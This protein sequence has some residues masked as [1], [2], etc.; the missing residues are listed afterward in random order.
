VRRAPLA[1]GLAAL[2]LTASPAAAVG[3]VTIGQLAPGTIVSCSKNF[4][5]LQDSSPDNAYVMPAAGVIT[6]WAHRSQAGA[7]QKVSLKIFR[8]IGDP[9]RYQL[10][11]HDG[12]HPVVAGT[13][14]TFPASIA[15]NAGDVLGLT[16]ESGSA[17]IG[18][19]FN[20]PGET[21]SHTPSLADGGFADFNISTTHRLNLTAVLN[22][23]N[24][25]TLGSIT[26]HK[27]KGTASLAVNLPNPGELTAS[28]AGAS[29]SGAAVISKVV[30]A[31]ATSLLIKAKGKKR[32][33]LNA[34]GKVKLNLTITYSPTGGDPSSQSVKVKLKKK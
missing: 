20:G 21:A 23:A 16:G 17:S 6:S 29:A 27:K 4:D 11:G 8:K 26:R 10:V 30:S 14:T 9:T 15:V 1:I 25:F 13:D 24:T 3:S 5:F 32:K 33:T 34:T 2:A 28:G 19:E 7:G 22:P 18:C 31:G 12:P